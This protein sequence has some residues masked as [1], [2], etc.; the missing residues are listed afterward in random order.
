MKSLLQ[1]L[2]VSFLISGCSEKKKNSPV[3]EIKDEKS[4]FDLMLPAP[5]EGE[6]QMDGYWVWGMSVIKGADGKY[7]GF[8]SAWENNVP[9]MSNWETNSQIVHTISDTPEG[10]YKLSEIVFERRGSSYWDGMM[11]H[12]PTIHKVGDTYLLY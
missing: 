4:F 10:P 3:P 7:H 11:T 6:F 1:F 5:R 2:F 9:F 8:S 12:N